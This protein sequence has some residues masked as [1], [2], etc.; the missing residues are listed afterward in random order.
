MYNSAPLSVPHAVLEEAE[1]EDFLIPKETMVLTH[2]QSVHVDPAC[3]DDP[4]TFNPDRF[5]KD[6]ALDK[7]E[8]YM[9]YSIGKIMLMFFRFMKT[10]FAC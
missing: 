5:I 10:L 8:A 4:D 2:L 3:W 6:G 9:P 1:F 7:K